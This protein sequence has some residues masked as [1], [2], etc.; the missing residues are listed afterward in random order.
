MRTG[1]E[2]TNLEGTARGV[3]TDGHVAKSGPNRGTLTVMWIGGN[4]P[5]SEWPDE[6]IAVPRA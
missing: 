3:V 2:V 5:V 6:L 4:Y 1:T